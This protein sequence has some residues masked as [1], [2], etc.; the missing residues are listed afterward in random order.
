[1]KQE[2]RHNILLTEIQIKECLEKLYTVSNTKST[3]NYQWFLL[4]IISTLEN[5]KESLTKQLEEA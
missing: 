5:Q 3:T 2:I 1:M 4:A